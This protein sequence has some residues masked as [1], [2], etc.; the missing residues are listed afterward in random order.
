MQD[1]SHLSYH[2]VLSANPTSADTTMTATSNLTQTNTTR[3][4]S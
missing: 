3:K 1:I 2:E 4:H